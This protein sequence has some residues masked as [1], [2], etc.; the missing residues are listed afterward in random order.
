METFSPNERFE[1]DLSKT[2]T[3]NGYCFWQQI[4]AFPNHLKLG[5]DVELCLRKTYKEESER[6]KEVANNLF[7]HGVLHV[8]IKEDAMLPLI[9]N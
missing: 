8:T 9:G 6:P 7:P 5:M 1:Q 3:R 4:D 2:K